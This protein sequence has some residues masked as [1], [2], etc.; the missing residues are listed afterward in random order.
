[1]RSKQVSI[2]P[3]LNVLVI[4][5]ICQ[6][7]SIYAKTVGPWSLD[8]AGRTELEIQLDPYYSAVDYIFSLTKD[9]IPRIDSEKE[10]GIYSYLIRNFL[11]PRFGLVEISLNPLPVAGVILKREARGFYDNSEFFKSERDP[12]A[13][14]GQSTGI[15]FIKALTVGFPEPGALSFFLGNVGNFTD[16][17]E[18]NAEIT[19]KGYSGFLLSIGN[20]HILN[21]LL[22]ADYWGES[23]MKLKGDDIKKSR[24]M[25]WSFRVG[26]KA[27]SHPEIKNTLYLSIKRDRV[28]FSKGKGGLWAFFY[29]NSEMEGR[30]D[31]NYDLEPANYLLLGGKKF[32]ADSGNWAFSLSVGV[33]RQTLA[34]YKGDLQNQVD[35]GW[36]LVIRPNV[37]F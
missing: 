21:N 5:I 30:V 22:I 23:E 8:S 27:H 28:D 14:D 9:P 10:S 26:S 3:F 7:N 12:N 31:L 29:E 18:A 36:S 1:M 35:E 33:L 19:G 16:G 6:C 13:P 20:Y 4:G 17:P 11:H 34:G 37:V 2:K 32:P 15:N 24:K 25:S